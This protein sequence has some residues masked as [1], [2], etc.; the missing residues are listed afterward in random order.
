MDIK[1]ILRLLVSEGLYQAVQLLCH[2]QQPGLVLKHLFS[3]GSRTAELVG[4]G[5]MAEQFQGNSG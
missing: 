4:E 3:D 1:E 5:A 2:R